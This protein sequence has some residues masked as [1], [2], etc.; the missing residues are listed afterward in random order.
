[1][2]GLYLEIANMRYRMTF[3]EIVGTQ[4]IERFTQEKYFPNY[5]FLN[6]WVI[7]YLQTSNVWKNKNMLVKTKTI[8]TP[9]KATIYYHA[10]Q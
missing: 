1:M 5:D 4:E 7:E 6:H 3:F 2:M 9:Q 10:E 8:P